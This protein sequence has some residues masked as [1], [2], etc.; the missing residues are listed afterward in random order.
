MA[1]EDL[2][3]SLRTRA[4]LRIDFAGG[5]TDHTA[6]VDPEGGCVVSAAIDACVHVDFLTEGKTIRL[7]SE[8]NGEHVTLTSPAEI[9]YDG[10]LDRQKAA[11]NMFPW[12]GGIEVLSRSDVPPGSGLGEAAALDTALIAGLA[13]CRL[14]EYD[15]DELVE[16]GLLLE[17]SELGL[18]GARQDHYPAV[19]GGFLEL[20]FLQD[21]IERETLAIGEEAAADLAN[22]LVLVYTGQSHFSARTSNR[23]WDAYDSGDEGSVGALRGMRDVAREVRPVLEGG[24]WEALAGLLNRNWEYQ[25]QLDATMSTPHIRSIE[26]TVRTAGAWGLKTTGD[27]GGGCFAVICPTDRREPIAAAAA[28]RGAT[29]LDVRFTFDGVA[30]TQLDDSSSNA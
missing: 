24:D 11:L 26:E 22:H 13:C 29:T 21:R 9:V 2:Q 28:A 27:G 19:L 15:V 6:F 14:E 5:W 30:V 17:S 4:P 12:T 3:L 1:D 20:K 23:V 16:L 25:Q 8:E 18:A 10:K 7:R